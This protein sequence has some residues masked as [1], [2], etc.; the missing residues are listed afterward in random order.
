[1]SKNNDF[2]LDAGFS[3]ILLLNAIRYAVILPIIRFN[4][5]K[6]PSDQLT[7]YL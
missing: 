4:I 5:F 7:H 2:S 1:M 6:G 3:L